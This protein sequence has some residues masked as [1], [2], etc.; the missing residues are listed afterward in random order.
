MDFIL[1][2]SGPFEFL[3]PSSWTESASSSQIFGQSPQQSA[4]QLKIVDP[5][6]KESYILID[7]GIPTENK[8]PDDLYAKETQYFRGFTPTS[9]PEGWSDNPFRGEKGDLRWHG[10]CFEYPSLDGSSRCR[11][12]ARTTINIRH[13][14]GYRWAVNS[15]IE[16]V[17]TLV[18]VWNQLNHKIKMIRSKA[19]LDTRDLNDTYQLPDNLNFS[20]IPEEIIKLARDKR[21]RRQFLESSPDSTPEIIEGSLRDWAIYFVSSGILPT[22]PDVIDAERYRELL[23]GT[24]NFNR[25]RY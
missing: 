13:N 20:G 19:V 16:K 17:D 5:T 21:R 1:W 4:T 2:R 7:Y 11:Q 25:F 15:R 14:D 9:I 24:D 8:S 6:D 12:Y 18:H 23:L 3:K 22:E 10:V